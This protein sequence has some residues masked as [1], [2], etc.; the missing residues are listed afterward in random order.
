[1]AEVMMVGTIHLGAAGGHLHEIDAGD[2]LAE[3]RQRE[4]LE[5]VDS[6]C[7]FHPTKV[8]VEWPAE[9]AGRL[10]EQFEAYEAG[11][12]ELK[13]SEIYQLGFRIARAER[14]GLLAID[15]EGSWYDPAIEDLI[16][17]S[18]ELASRW[19]EMF[20]LGEADTEATAD[21]LAHQGL[22]AA[23]ARKNR[24]EVKLEEFRGYMGYNL[25]VNEVGALVG[26]DMV[27][28]WWQRNMRIAANLDRMIEDDDRVI[29]VY[30]AGH[31]PFLEY[32]WGWNPR[33][34]L[35]DPLPYL[36]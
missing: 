23:L 19:Q 36:A 30:G 33:M 1:M 6:L 22:R 35:V 7:S 17:N 3:D 31:A 27:A 25:W 28:D 14:A 26:A 34:T 5:L 29:V 9:L 24:A 4:L 18:A 16:A 21:A 32:L 15:V 12:F 10:Q 20:V 11:T 2:T 8:A 13:E